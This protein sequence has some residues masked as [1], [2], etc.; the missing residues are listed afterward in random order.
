M[1]HTPSIYICMFH[2][3]GPVML[4]VITARR[5]RVCCGYVSECNGREMRLVLAAV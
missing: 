2:T 1:K 5:E 3:N 4:D